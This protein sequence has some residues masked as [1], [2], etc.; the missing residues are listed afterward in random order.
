[1]KGINFKIY[2]IVGF[3]IILSGFL[4]SEEL[5]QLADPMAEGIKDQSWRLKV[6]FEKL[7]SSSCE[8]TLPVILDTNGRQMP[9]RWNIEKVITNR[10]GSR[11]FIA[12]TPQ[13]SLTEMILVEKNNRLLGTIQYPGA[14]LQINPLNDSIHELTLLNPDNRPSLIND[15]RRTGMPP[16]WEPQRDPAAAATVIDVMVVYT[17]DTVSDNGGKAAVDQ[18]VD[19]F[20]TST[21]TAYQNSGISQRVS[22][23]HTAQLNYDEGSSKV[24]DML[25]RLTNKNDGYMDYV[26]T[27]RDTHKADLVCLLCMDSS[28]GGQG[29]LMENHHISTSF[30]IYGFSVVSMAW[31]SGWATGSFSH[32]LGHNMGGHHDWYVTSSPGAYNYSHGYTLH[33]KLA[34]TLMA[35]PNDCNSKVVLS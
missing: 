4:N 35:Y 23:V 25:T 3:C 28:S 11:S 6:D 29:W 20:V 10:S 18:M 13:Q 9:Q 32:E 30:E 27:L 5:F 24:S 33:D 7:N 2:L 21:N 19:L 14:F 12:R 22:L 8:I 26:H 15:A 16:V 17:N 31:G 34:Y 1:M